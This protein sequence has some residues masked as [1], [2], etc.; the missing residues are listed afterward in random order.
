MSGACAQ[1]HFRR[2]CLARGRSRG[3]TL[4]EMIGVLTIISTLAA[5]LVPNIVRT[6]DDAIGAAESD[7]LNALAESLESV[8]LRGKQIPNATGWVA[9]L[10]TET[11]MSTNK[12]SRNERGLLRGYYV[13]PRFFTAVDTPFAP[14]SQNG[15]LANAP[16]SPRILLVSDLTGNASAAPTTAAAFNAIWNQTG[17]PSVVEGPRVKIERINLG[18]WF[19]PTLIVNQHS[20]NA[21]YQVETGTRLSLA[22]VGAGGGTGIT[23]YL[24]KNSRVSLFQPPFPSGALERVVLVTQPRELSYI[25][26]LGASPV[27]AWSVL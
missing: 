3:F 12:I 24:L 7:N 11:S 18:A 16:N 5:V 4:I 13:D 10:T 17:T 23:R 21:S 8:V 27:W 1:P 14:Y 2:S 6:V 9:M 20:A 19:V 22:T 25:S 26:S 15:G